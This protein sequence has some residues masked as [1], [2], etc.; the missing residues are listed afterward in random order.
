MAE[1]VGPSDRPWWVRVL[2]PSWAKRRGLVRRLLIGNV[3]CGLWA[4]LFTALA[5]INE[6]SKY[7]DYRW[8]MLAFFAAGTVGFVCEWQAVRWMDRADAWP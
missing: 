7:H 1:K 8:W 3:L 5:F 2:I 4:I 6:Q